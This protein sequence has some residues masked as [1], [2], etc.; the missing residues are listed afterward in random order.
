MI[1][2]F[3]SISMP[4]PL[5]LIRRH[6]CTYPRLPSACLNTH[7]LSI[8]TLNRLAFPRFAATRSHRRI[9]P[10]QP[11]SP[12]PSPFVFRVLSLP[13]PSP[14]PV[15]RRIFPFCISSVAS[16]ITVVA[17]MS[18]APY[19]L[20]IA[21][22]LPFPRCW[23]LNVFIPLLPDVRFYPSRSLYFLCLCWSVCFTFLFSFHTF[24][25]IF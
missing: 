17:V 19:L 20:S 23:L 24:C 4:L 25:F 12:D 18:V 10:N 2:G 22:W 21:S 16:C 13:L 9:S 15:S 8:W 11:L 14:I 7:I 6:R 3:Y 1:F 5:F